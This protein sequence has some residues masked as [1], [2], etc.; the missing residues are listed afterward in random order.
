M[1]FITKFQ[2]KIYFFFSV[3]VKIQSGKTTSD[4]LFKG[5]KNVIGKIENMHTYVVLVTHS[6]A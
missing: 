6:N 1:L 5:E 2:R 3:D 4:N